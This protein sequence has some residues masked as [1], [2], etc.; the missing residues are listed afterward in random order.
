MIHC[1]MLLIFPLI[2]SM[3]IFGT[4]PKS[5]YDEQYYQNYKLHEVVS[6]NLFDGDLNYN[7]VGFVDE[8]AVSLFIMENV[9]YFTCQL[10]LINIVFNLY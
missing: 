6:G 9:C 2:E 3:L 4:P 5:P 8:I 10:L 1:L 7:F